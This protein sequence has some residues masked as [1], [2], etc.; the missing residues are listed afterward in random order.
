MTS[1]LKPALVLILA[2]A[3][4]VSPFLSDSFNG[5]DPNQFPNPQIN[6]PVQPIGWAFAIWGVIYLG[7]ILHAGFGLF[8]HRD[9][10]VW[11][12]GRWPL[13]LSLGVGAI[14]IPVANISPIWASV[15]IWLML[16]AVLWSLHRAHTATP[17]WVASWPVGLCAGWLSAACFVSIGLLLGGYGLMAEGPAAILCLVLATGFALFWQIRLRLWTY[18]A[19]VVWAFAGIAFAN[20]ET[21]LVIAVLS[22]GA[23]L[24]V[25]IAAVSTSRKT[26]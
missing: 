8:A 20:A 6:P 25:A 2:I 24:V 5:F 1:F 9:D 3:F 17:S 26:A 11:N 19:A 10:P 4:A 14:W 15:L 21:S 7:L 23:A 22:A 12:M 13:I 16:I 18:G